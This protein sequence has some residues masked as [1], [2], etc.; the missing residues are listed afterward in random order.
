[1]SKISPKRLLPSC[2]FDIHV[3]VSTYRLEI[4]AK[5]QAESAGRDLA[6]VN[7]K[8]W[9]NVSS[10]ICPLVISRRLMNQL[11]PDDHYN[12]NYRERRAKN[13]NFLVKLNH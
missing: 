11:V 7:E 2:K 3:C 13:G 1:M 5:K 10:L 4:V 12:Y 9:G 8:A 6:I